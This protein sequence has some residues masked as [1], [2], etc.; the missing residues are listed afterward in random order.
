[1]IKANFGRDVDY[2]NV[3]GIA[4]LHIGSQDV[5]LKELGTL[6]KYGNG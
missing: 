4:D 6:E 5:D 3:Y 2:V 1:M